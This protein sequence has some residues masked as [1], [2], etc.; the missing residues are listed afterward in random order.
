M[1]MSVY[2]APCSPDSYK[3]AN[4]L[5]SSL[6]C[7]LIH[8]LDGSYAVNNALESYKELVIYDFAYF[9]SSLDNLLVTCPCRVHLV[10]TP[11]D[12]KHQLSDYL[13]NHLLT[14]FPETFI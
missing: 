14:H 4:K 5:S 6:E 7:P 10:G 11:F 12:P 8:G 3:Y 9:T 13:Y 1:I 2:T